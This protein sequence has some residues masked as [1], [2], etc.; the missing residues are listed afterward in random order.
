LDLQPATLAAT[1]HVCVQAVRDRTSYS[2]WDAELSGGECQEVFF[3]TALEERLPE[4]IRDLAKIVRLEKSDEF[5]R[6][7][8]ENPDEHQM[9]RDVA[10]EKLKTKERSP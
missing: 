3:G 9:C 8:K 4:R 1:Q 5:K 6:C 7:L 2:T 10:E